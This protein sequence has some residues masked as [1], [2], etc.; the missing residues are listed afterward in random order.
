M[1]ADLFCKTM[2]FYLKRNR[3]IKNRKTLKILQ[4][5]LHQYLW[6]SRQFG[7]S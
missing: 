7:N 3:T 4:L 1:Y 6:L 5:K 2:T